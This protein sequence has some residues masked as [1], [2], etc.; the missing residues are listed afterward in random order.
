MNVNFVRK[1]L[2]EEKTLKVILNQLMTKKKLF[3]CELC[4]K[5]FNEEEKL[6]KSY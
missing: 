4:Q 2:V 6:Q 5:R 1:D 3:E